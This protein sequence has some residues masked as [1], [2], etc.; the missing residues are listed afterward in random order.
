MAEKSDLVQQW[1]KI[2]IKTFTKWTNSHLAKR[3]LKLDS[4]TE[5][6]KTG[7]NLAN[8]LEVIS[9]EPLGKFDKNPKMRI[10]QVENVG[11]CLKFISEHG[12]KLAGIGAEEIVDGNVKMT[13]GM[14]WTIILRFAIAGLSE[15]G[16]SAKEGL[17]LW[18]RRKTEPYDNVDVKDFTVSFQDGL[19]FCALIH[20]HRP[21]LID[22]H[23]LTA[24][25]KLGN[26]N[27]AFD[28]AL[29]HLDV[30]RLLDAEDIVN[31][32]RPD[33]RSIMTYVAQL[34]KV[35]SSLDKVETAGR[36]VA[37]FVGFNKSLNELIEEYE[38]RTRALNS[39]VSS[40]TASL[41][42][43]PLGDDYSSAKAQIQAFR[44]YKK[45]QRRAWVAEQ[46]ELVSLFGNIQAK[47]KSFNRP[48]YVP[49]SG[50]S[51]QDVTNNFEGLSVSEVNR[52]TSLNNNL[53]NIL[54]ALRRAFANVA[55]PFHDA[56]AALRS[57]LTNDSG[58]LEDQ[59]A[60]CQNKSAELSSL[61]S[62]L[63]AI[64]QAEQRTLDANIEDN[65][66]SEHTYDD[67]DFEY[68]Q[69]VKTYTKKIG[70]LES[71]ILA[72][73]ESRNI[74]PEQLQEFKETFTHFDSQKS[75]KL[76]RLD[77]KAA[78]SGL[79]LVELDFEGGNAVF[80]AL[81][82]RVSDGSDSISFSQF[83][84]YMISVTLDTVSQQQLD[85]SF[86]VI[87]GNK[88][89]VTVADLRVAQLSQD[90]IDYLTSVMPKHPSI[91]DAYNYRAW[92]AT[93]F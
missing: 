70:F 53:R 76:S 63:P 55:N 27:L 13:L 83:T 66:Y 71:Q 40:K 38:R 46:A 24:E 47:Q 41:G 92:L 4:L 28:V 48:N 81:F 86:A 5:D 59:L 30:P 42:S 14:I 31:M 49:P 89:H 80:E 25:D 61:R 8:L 85:D 54:D 17:L 79:G 32:P 2:Q 19:A 1:E 6:L 73:S 15:E 75:G 78:L 44:D 33:E 64:Q 74:T 16:L 22:Y 20:R 43:D 50:L 37:K 35:F 65:E 67:L 87:A 7:V 72:A 56:L 68:G 29:Q 21:D 18:C 9:E 84:D 93:Q 82:K 11:K 58:S 62:Q 26:L 69:L 90:Q 88:D 51:P 34:Y 3:G 45:N 39:S 60:F 91:P 10:Q 52:R 57:A 12:V 36:R 23:K 77:F